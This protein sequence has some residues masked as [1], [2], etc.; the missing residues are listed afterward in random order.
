M[1]SMDDV[2]FGSKADIRAA[3]CHV[4]FT[5]ERSAMGQER[6][7]LVVDDVIGSGKQCERDSEAERLGRFEIDCQ[8]VLGRRGPEDQPGFRP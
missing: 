7:S 5:P 3:K 4:R 1:L 6:T 8:L 2:R